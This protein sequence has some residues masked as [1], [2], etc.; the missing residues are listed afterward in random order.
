MPNKVLQPDLSALHESAI[1]VVTQVCQLVEQGY[2]LLCEHNRLL[3]ADQSEYRLDTD[4]NK[5]KEELRYVKNILEK[6]QKLELTLTIVAPT[7]AGKSTI[8]NAIAGQDLLP[9]RNDAMTILPT[10][11]VFNC[12]VTQPRLIVEEA[13]T[14]Q[15][16]SFWQQLYKITQTLGF[17]KAIEQMNNEDFPRKDLLKELFSQPTV[18]FSTQV[19]DSKRIQSTLIKVND[20]FRLCNIFGVATEFLS[21]LQ[22]I[23]RIEVPFP[24][25]VSSLNILGTL[26]LVDTPGPNEVKSLNLVNIIKDRLK[27]SAMI[28]LV[29][30]YTKIGQTAPEEVKRLVDEIAEVKGRDRVY[31]IVNKIDQRDPKNSQDLTTEQVFELIKT[32]Y[33]ITNVDNRVFELSGRQAFLAANFWRELDISHNKEIREMGAV[34]ALGV[35][36]YANSWEEKQSDIALGEIQKAA[37]KIW[38]ISKFDFLKKTIFERILSNNRLVVYTGLKDAGSQLSSFEKCLISQK[39]NLVLNIEILDREIN[40]LKSRLSEISLIYQDHEMWRKK[41]SDWIGEFRSELNNFFEEMKKMCLEKLSY[42]LRAV[43]DRI[44]KATDD[45]NMIDSMLMPPADWSAVSQTEEIL[46]EFF[47]DFAKETTSFCALRFIPSLVRK[48]NSSLREYHDHP[49]FADAKKDLC[50][51]F[52]CCLQSDYESLI[53]SYEFKADGWIFDFLVSGGEKEIDHNK[54]NLLNSGTFIDFATINEL[55][56]ENLDPEN[57]SIKV[58]GGILFATGLLSAISV[59]HSFTLLDVDNF[60]RRLGNHNNAD[61]SSSSREGKKF[62]DDLTNLDDKRKGYA[63]SRDKIQAPR[64]E[65]LAAMQEC[66]MFFTISAVAYVLDKD[67]ESIVEKRDLL[68][69]EY[70]AYLRLCMNEK[71]NNKK[72]YLVLNNSYDQLLDQVKLLSRSISFQCEYSREF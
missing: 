71:N 15:L 25:Y 6:I 2:E 21:S 20:I 1:D 50:I 42:R 54:N 58:I 18:T 62:L 29:L 9:S 17:E 26:A 60:Y 33:E 39:A 67:I 61:Y 41:L 56:I 10:E 31:L 7:S 55:D 49:I 59:R 47:D 69:N 32:K 35:E 12:E 11:I 23:P 24:M 38:E 8:I 72:Q 28:L 27:A 51:D 40:D 44:V 13:L 66:M 4:I 37:K 22:K 3:A 16:Q 36:Y 52:D 53:R 46:R 19:E 63:I 14:I 68:L 65:E 70:E 34:E 64:K 57:P 5:L 43:E 30:D 45:R 48:I